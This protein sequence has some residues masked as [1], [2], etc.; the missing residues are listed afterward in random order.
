[1]ITLMAF[2]LQMWEPSGN[3]SEIWKCR[4]DR[5]REGKK[6]Y[7]FWRVNFFDVK[8]PM[9]WPSLG[10]DFRFIRDLWW[11][12]SSVDICSPPTMIGNA[13]LDKIHLR[14]SYT[15]LKFLLC[16]ENVIKTFDKV[17]QQD[18][19]SYF[20]WNVGKTL[21]LTLF[22]NSKTLLLFYNNL[23]YWYF[24]NDSVNLYTS[25]QIFPVL[26]NLTIMP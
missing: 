25:R 17:W 26:R 16:S 3:T 5:R 20:H 14:A 15:Q 12:A 19:S 2:I 6:G 13:V 11:A 9:A 21:F 18:L 4:P 22:I 1:M 24:H 10:L 23:H 7:L 8:F